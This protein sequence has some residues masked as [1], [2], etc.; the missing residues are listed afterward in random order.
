MECTIADKELRCSKIYREV[1]TGWKPKTSQDEENYKQYIMESIYA[2][3]EPE[4][5]HEAQTI[6]ETTAGKSLIII[7][8]ESENASSDARPTP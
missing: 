8:K 1:Q 2:E 7:A 4:T 3:G 6:I 5:I